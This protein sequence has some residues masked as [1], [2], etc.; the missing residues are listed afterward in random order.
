VKGLAGLGWSTLLG[1]DHVYKVP[2]E[3]SP[4]MMQCTSALFGSCQQLGV[5][6]LLLK[7][8]CLLDWLGWWLYH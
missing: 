8:L 5:L 3:L 7:V 1:A 2:F 6:G 4:P